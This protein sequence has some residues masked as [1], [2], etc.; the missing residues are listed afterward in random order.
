MPKL[1]DMDQ[2]QKLSKEAIEEFKQI[3]HREFMEMLP[4]AAA[5]ELAIRILRLFSL[6]SGISLGDAGSNTKPPTHR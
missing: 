2:A 5:E 6:L 1:N 4:D 3:Y